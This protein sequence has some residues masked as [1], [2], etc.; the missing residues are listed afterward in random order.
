LPELYPQQKAFVE[1]QARYTVVEATVK[2]GKTCACLAWILKLAF[3]P[4]NEGKVFWWV[5][6]IFPQTKIAYRRLKGWL[7]ERPELAKFNES[8]LMVTLAN[9]AVITFKGADN[10]DSLYGESVFGAVI[11]EASRCKEEAWHAVRSTL[12]ST[13]GPLKIIGNVR[14]RKNWA[15]QLARRAEAG[16]QGLSYHKL[17]AWDAVE[18]GVLAAEEIEDAKR[19][20]PEAVF[21]EL[22]LA[23]PSDDGGNPFGLDAI[24]GCVGELSAEPPVAIGVDLAKSA[25][26]TVVI[27]VDERGRCCLYER[28]QDSWQQTTRRLVDILLQHQEAVVQVDSTGVGDPIVEDLQQTVP[29]VE[30]FKFSSTSKQQ[31]MEGLAVAIQRGEIGY[32]EGPIAAELRE[33]EYSVRRTGVS[34]SAPEGLHDDC[35]CALALA[36]SG[37]RRFMPLGISTLDGMERERERE[38]AGGRVEREPEEIMVRLNAWTERD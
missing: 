31:L 19:L 32:P 13:R 10:P 5:A 12:T 11:D 34:Y 3:R 27:G 14:G 33:F 35:V 6:P 28:W 38:Q 2:A 23:E 29:N 25:D 24:E 4:G 20:L 7:T 36:V 16:E 30:G 26:W 17:T 21:R 37:W 1:D 18:A 15:Y 8:E 22:Y 9:G